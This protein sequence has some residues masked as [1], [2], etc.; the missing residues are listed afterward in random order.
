[1]SR[2]GSCVCDARGLAFVAAPRDGDAGL[3]GDASGATEAGGTG[4]VA[5]ADG[6][7]EK[8]GGAD[9]S[10]GDAGAGDGA[11]T[12]VTGGARP[13][14]LSA[15]RISLPRIWPTYHEENTDSWSLVSGRA[16]A[17]PTRQT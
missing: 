6:R 3:S 5:M 9:W 11:S 12:I 2:D 8:P 17:S 4:P 7:G 10:A 13:T 14:V 1:M 15:D 16:L